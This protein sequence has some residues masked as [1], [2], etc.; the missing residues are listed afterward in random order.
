MPA[1][2]WETPPAFGGETHSRSAIVPE[3]NGNARGG[4]SIAPNPGAFRVSR[5]RQLRLL[6][7]VEK[8]SA[9]SPVRRPLRGREP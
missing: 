6:L 7:R 5:W 1:L 8:R 9:M 3:V 2:G 4:V